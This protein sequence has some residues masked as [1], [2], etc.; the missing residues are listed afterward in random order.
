MVCPRTCHRNQLPGDELMNN[1][2]THQQAI[3]DDDPKKCGLFLGTGSGKTRTALLLA[4]GNTLV[5]APKTQVE[6]GN[7]IR[8]YKDALKTQFE[9]AGR[10][11]IFKPP[12]EKL[13]VISKE[14]F[15]RDHATLPRFDTVIVDEAHTCLGVTPNTKQRKGIVTPRTSQLFEALETFLERTQPERL[16]L[17]TA[18]I[19][20]SPM[21]VWGACKLLMTNHYWGIENFYAFR[22]KFYTKLPMPGRDVWVPKRDD[23]SKDNLA[24]VV[25]EL[26]YTG[27]LQDFFDVPEQTFITKHIEL[28]AAQK[29]RIKELP[30]EYPDPL[31]LIG[32]KLQ[33]ENGI[34]NGD[35]FNAPESFENGKIDKILELAEEFPRMIVFCKYR[36]QLAAIDEVLSAEGYRTALLHGDI[37]DRGGLIAYANKQTDCIFICM[38]QISAGWELPTYPVVVYA[39]RT[40]SW[41]DYEQSLG[42]VQRAN[43]IKKNLY[44]HL[45]VKGG[46]D[47]AVDKVLANKADFNERLY[48]GI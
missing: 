30:L 10:S 1:L 42:R 20:K 44:V 38:A 11:D 37:Q 3:I 22:E 43:N 21:T 16:Y 47:E 32:K 41:V 12:T 23:K 5:I 2:Y 6:D 40:Y 17:C 27:R 29:K 33:V 13:T 18:T 31:V 14:G 39:S 9:M 46:V 28:T 34:L 19:V 25:K 24:A 48:I 36:A 35:E 4:R 15:R 8:E 45:V 26:G 7:W